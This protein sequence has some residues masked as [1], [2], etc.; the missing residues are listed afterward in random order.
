MSNMSKLKKTMTD[1]TFSKQIGY[2]A[3]CLVRILFV[4]FGGLILAGM[5]LAYQPE[6][7]TL[8]DSQDVQNRIKSCEVQDQDDNNNGLTRPPGE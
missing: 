7:E 2:P 1:E 5:I 4:V 3:G 8:K 6:N